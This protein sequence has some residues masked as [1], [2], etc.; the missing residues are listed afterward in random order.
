MQPTFYDRILHYDALSENAIQKIE[1]LSKEHSSHLLQLINAETEKIIQEP[2]N[3][4]EI[5]KRFSLGI[6]FYHEEMKKTEHE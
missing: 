2:Q 6:Y 5:K 3:H 1:A 4:S